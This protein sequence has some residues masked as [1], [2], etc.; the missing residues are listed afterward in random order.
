MLD[1]KK[2]KDLCLGDY[3]Y[4]YTSK[5]GAISIEGMVKGYVEVILTDDT[6]LVYK[7]TDVV[8]LAKTPAQKP[9]TKRDLPRLHRQVRELEESIKQ[10][11]DSVLQ[12]EADK[13]TD[14]WVMILKKGADSYYFT[15]P[16][17]DDPFRLNYARR[18]VY[19]V[20]KVGSDTLRKGPQ[21]DGK[22]LEVTGYSQN[23]WANWWHPDHTL[24]EL[25]VKRGKGYVWIEITEERYHELVA[26]IKSLTFPEPVLTT[27]NPE[28]T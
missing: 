3:I 13:W 22:S 1:T 9:L 28:V 24:V 25:P 15:N 11:E 20:Y 7:S 16:G 21:R 5:V 27:E 8:E 12:E 6:R 14:K 17:E 26:I 23:H 18:M 2:A 4:P 10:I 19:G